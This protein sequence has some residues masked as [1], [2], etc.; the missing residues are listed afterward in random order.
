MPKSVI[1]LSLDDYIVRWINNQGMIPSRFLNE[2]L[3]RVYENQKSGEVSSVEEAEILLD[4]LRQDKEETNRKIDY[5]I[6][7]I[8]SLIKEIKAKENETKEGE[9]RAKPT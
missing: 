8:E 6:M 7:S 5:N 2:F 9:T 3:K 1:T 4:K